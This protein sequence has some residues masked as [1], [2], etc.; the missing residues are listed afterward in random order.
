MNYNKDFLNDYEL[1]YQQLE[2]DQE[3]LVERQREMCQ[4]NFK[5]LE[6]VRMKEDNNYSFAAE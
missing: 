1:C 3:K 4:R 5:Y 6:F 2:K